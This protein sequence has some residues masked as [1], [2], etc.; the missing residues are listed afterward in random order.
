MNA[1]QNNTRLIS[2][3][4]APGANS[5]M[6]ARVVYPDWDTLPCEDFEGA[7]E[8]VRTGKASL[9]MIPV[10]NSIAGRVADIHHLLP[11]GGLSIIGEYFHPVVHSLLV[12][13]GTKLDDIREV[14]SHVQA[15]GQCRNTIRVLG[16]KPVVAA[17]TAGAAAD[18]ARDRDPTRAAIASS[19][20]A[21]I[22]GLEVLREGV[23]DAG[24]NTTRFIIMAREP[25]MPEIGTSPCMT[26]FVFR[27]R[28][29][30]AAL[31]KALGGF[32]TNG[33]N[34]TKLESYVDSSFTQAQFF[35]ETEGHIDDPRLRRA[36]EELEFF[37][38]SLHIVGCYPAHPFRKTLARLAE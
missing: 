30:P 32:A 28:S 22:Y 10:E 16:L 36:L 19:L 35:A 20:A 4:G 38:E 21:K 2:F 34:M 5:D 37:A 15:L 8:A 24:H 29:V 14:H 1:V 13:P 31:Y 7:F 25:Q 6:A 11:Q 33:V 3:Q 26:S 23:E 9:A 17:D 12:L 27:V 18:V